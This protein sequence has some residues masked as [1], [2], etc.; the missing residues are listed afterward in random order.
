MYRE[1]PRAY[2]KAYEPEVEVEVDFATDG[3]SASSSWC[4]APLWCSWPDFNFLIFDNYFHRVGRPLWWEDGSVVWRE[5]TH[6]YDS[7]RTRNHTWLS[8]LRLLQ[9]GGP[10]PRVYIFQEQGGPVIPRGTGFPFCRLLRV[11]GLWW[12]YSNQP[13]HGTYEPYLL[14]GWWTPLQQNA[15]CITM[16]HSYLNSITIHGLWDPWKS[17]NM[18]LCKAHFII[19]QHGWK[20]NLPALLCHR[21]IQQNVMNSLRSRAILKYLLYLYAK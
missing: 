10:D 8:H 19:G 9:L 20:S 14:R 12:R 7:S 5:I 17:Q 13:T 4:R 11:A 15:Q 16:P 21:E 2:L 3:E 18:A 6:W 1:L